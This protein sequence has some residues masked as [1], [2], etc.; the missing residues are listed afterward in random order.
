MKKID[1]LIIAAIVITGI[2][3]F[4]EGRLSGMYLSLISAGVVVSLLVIKFLMKRY[5]QSS[6]AK[7]DAGEQ[8]V[9]EIL[10]KWSQERGFISMAYKCPV[11]KIQSKFQSK[12]HQHIDILCDSPDFINLGIEVKYRETD[13]IEFLHFDSISKF[14]SSGV[15]QTTRQL[16]DF[17]SNTG[18]LGLYAFLLK[19]KSGTN[20][21]FLPHFVLQQ[22]IDAGKSSITIKKITT[23]SLSYQWEDGNKDFHQ[24]AENQYQL[25]KRYLSSVGNQIEE[26]N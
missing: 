6:F 13:Q 19:D 11:E 23:H 26:N 14:D 16:F 20:V 15:R 22:M 4:Y 5:S 25:Q 8:R 12:Y 2:A 3:L 10:N 17:I 7:G 1:L 24:Y 18:R 9:I 21:Y